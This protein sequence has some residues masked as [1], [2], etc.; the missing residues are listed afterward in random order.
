MYYTYPIWVKSLVPLPTPSHSPQELTCGQDDL[1]GALGE[2]H[3]PGALGVGL[4]H[5]GDLERDIPHALA[6]QTLLLSERGG[7]LMGERG[8]WVEEGS[9]SRTSNSVQNIAVPWHFRLI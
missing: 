8:W 4:G 3:D 5:L 9:M 7:L 2:D 6:R 1:V